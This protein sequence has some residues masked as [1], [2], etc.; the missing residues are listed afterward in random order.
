MK[1]LAALI[2]ILLTIN[3]AIA[4]CVPMRDK[5]GNIARSSWQVAKFRKSNPCP[6]T[7]LTTGRCAGYVVDHVIP[8]CLCGADNPS[9][10]QWQSKRE[11]AIKDIAENA[12]C[13]NK[14]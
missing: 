7:Q 4:D 10:M 11:A 13:R 5:S 1:T 3:I 6:S 9:N 14:P 12:Q 8:L 2:A